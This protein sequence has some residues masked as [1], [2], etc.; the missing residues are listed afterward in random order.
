[1]YIKLAVPAI[2]LETPEHKAKPAVLCAKKVYQGTEWND[3]ADWWLSGKNHLEAAFAAIDVTKSLREKAHTLDGTIETKAAHAAYYAAEAAMAAI[4]LGG[5][6][7]DTAMRV[8]IQSAMLAAMWL[9]GLH[10]AGI[11]MEVA[12]RSVKD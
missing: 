7:I 9:T 11:A 2:D 1:M 4:D 3:W 12:G 8:S 5:E 10:L 6:S